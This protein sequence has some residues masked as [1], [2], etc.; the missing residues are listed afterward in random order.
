M[1]W[2]VTCLSRVQAECGRCVGGK[3]GAP[4]WVASEGMK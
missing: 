3:D 1:F 4:E 2:D